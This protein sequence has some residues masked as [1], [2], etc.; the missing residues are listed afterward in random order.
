MSAAARGRSSAG[1]SV[2]VPV[3]ALTLLAGFATSAKAQSDQDSS[4][5]AEQRPER[6]AWVVEGVPDTVWV[7]LERAAAQ[8]ED[9]R[10]EDLLREAEALAR[11]SLVDH[12][13]NVGRRFALA[14]ALG[15]RAEREGGGGKVRAASALFEELEVILELD[16][17]HARARHMMGRLHAGVRRMNRITRWIATNLMGGDVLGEATWEEAE[18]HL[19]FAEE[20]APEVPDH[21]LQLARLYAHTERP[22]RAAEEVE[23]VL[24]MDPGSP[25]E[26]AAVAEARELQEELANR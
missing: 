15:M 23:H 21:H 2:R 24:A 18:R 20:Q 14:A 6:P 1:R 26:E 8:E 17:D 3:L 4:A 19:A 25:M 7:L 10:A 12:E 13:E 9:D 11:E 16:P 5:V 22:E